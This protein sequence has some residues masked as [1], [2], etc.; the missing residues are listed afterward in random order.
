MRAGILAPPCLCSVLSWK[1]VFAEH[2]MVWLASV[3]RA[4]LIRRH[5]LPG[6]Y[7][8]GGMPCGVSGLLIRLPESNSLRLISL[9]KSGSQV[10]LTRLLPVCVQEVRAVKTLR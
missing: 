7:T 9:L 2:V 8:D 5:L 1:R 3:R 4:S 10:F 6:T